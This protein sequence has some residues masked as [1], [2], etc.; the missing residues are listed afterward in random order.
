[1]LILN[2]NFTN[3]NTT[4]SSDELEILAYLKSWDGKFLSLVDI[5][6][7]ASGRQKF[8]DTPNW[9]NGLMGRLIDAKLV[10]ANERGHYRYV[11]ETKPPQPKAKAKLIPPLQPE[12]SKTASIVG[13]NYFPA[14]EPA[15]PPSPRWV[16]PQIEALLKQAGKNFPD[17]KKS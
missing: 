11:G 8:R 4:F 1:M 6:R 10:E 17:P 7:N 5:S 12:S 13:D 3:V 9:A 14:T 15:D 16:S 2:E